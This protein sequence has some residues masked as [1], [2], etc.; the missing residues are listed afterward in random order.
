MSARGAAKPKSDAEIDDIRA[1]CRILGHILKQLSEAV[2]E[3]ASG[4]DLSD[5]VYREC[6]GYDVIPAFEGQYGFPESLCVS[7]NEVVIHGIPNDIPFNDGDIVS[8]DCGVIYKGMYSDAARSIVVGSNSSA[9]H[10]V[11]QTKAAFDAGIATIKDGS[12]VGDI[13]AAVD[14]IASKHSLGNVDAFVGHGVG[15]GLHEPPEIPNHGKKGTGPILRAGMTIAVE[16][17]FTLGT[18]DIFIADD[19]WSVIPRD[20]SLGAHWENT[21]LVTESGSEILTLEH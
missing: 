15:K 21:V 12:S 3:G 2:V 7:V 18:K 13:G 9:E 4:M 10:L 20:H 11:K 8:F 6:R 16:P 14:K 19:G 1:S 5:I 17:M